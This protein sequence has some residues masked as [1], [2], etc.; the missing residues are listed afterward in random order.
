[1]MMMMMVMMMNVDGFEQL[2][3]ATI[4]SRTS[5]RRALAALCSKERTLGN[6]LAMLRCGA[7]RDVGRLTF[8]TKQRQK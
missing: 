5:Q 3:R 6:V 8:R 7:H 2:E 1:M 4:G